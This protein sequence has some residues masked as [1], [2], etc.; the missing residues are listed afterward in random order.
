MKVSTSVIV[1][2]WAW[3]QRSHF[4]HSRKLEVQRKD[5]HRFKVF[6]ESRAGGVYRV[7]A[8]T[9]VVVSPSSST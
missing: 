2:P 9:C 5:G 8:P 1:Q 7:T 3:A 6:L 4:P